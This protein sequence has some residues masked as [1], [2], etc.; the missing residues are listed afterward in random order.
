V[1]YE[2]EITEDLCVNCHK[3]L[4]N[5]GVG[6]VEGKGGTSLFS[7]IR[8]EI[9]MLLDAGAP[10]TEIADLCNVCFIT[11]GYWKR[12]LGFKSDNPNTKIVKGPAFICE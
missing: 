9:F 1:S 12:K 2:P 11:V 3:N 6:L 4:H 7:L 10:D 5:H 8:D